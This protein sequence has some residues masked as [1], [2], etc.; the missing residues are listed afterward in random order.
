M[1]TPKTKYYDDYENLNSNTEINN[2]EISYF[3]TEIKEDN[4]LFNYS[5][6][7]KKDD[8][9]NKNKDNN[10]NNNINIGIK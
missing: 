3:L 8:D 9:I 10:N 1:V 7:E 5:S 6:E 4:K 2:K